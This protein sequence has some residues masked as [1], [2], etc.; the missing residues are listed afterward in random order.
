M[1][2]RSGA[3]IPVI[4]TLPCTTKNKN[5]ECL[6]GKCH[7][8]WKLCLRQP[9]QLCRACIVYLTPSTCRLHSRTSDVLHKKATTV[10]TK[11]VNFIDLNCCSS[12]WQC[13]R[14][15]YSATCRTIPMV[16]GRSRV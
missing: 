16:Y 12:I 3:V 15:S 8:N 2:V 1:D 13:Y 4:L 11:V 6:G 7:G 5:A 14:I 9:L 10:D